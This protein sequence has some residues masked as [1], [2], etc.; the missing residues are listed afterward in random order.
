MRRPDAARRVTEDAAHRTGSV[1][2]SCS[3][4]MLFLFSYLFIR[5]LSEEITD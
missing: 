3:F 2:D 5:K 4:F 1:S